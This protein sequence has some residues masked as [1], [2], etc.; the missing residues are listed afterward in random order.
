MG[1]GASL[2]PS[3]DPPL[4]EGRG[5]VAAVEL[6]SEDVTQPAPA[7][8]PAA[9]QRAPQSSVS[10]GMEKL[11]HARET[12]TKND[13]ALRA[14]LNSTQEEALEPELE[15]VDPHHHAWDMRELEGFN[16]FG[17]FKQQYYMSDQLLDDMVGG[18]H[19]VTHSVYAEAHSFVDADTQDAAMAPL[20]EVMAM[21]GLA[22][23]FASGK[24]GKLRAVAGIIGTA[25][26]AK[27]GA[28]V[29]PLLLACKAAAPNFRGIRVNGQHD[30]GIKFGVSAPGLYRETKFR[31]GFAL[32]G[33]HGLSFD[34]FLYSP[35][36]EDLYDLATTF[37]ETTIILNHN[38]CPAG[39]LDSTNDKAD[40]LV[41]AWKIQMEKIA[42]ECPN[43]YVKVG[44]GGMPQLGH[45]FDQ[46]DKPPTS[47]EVAQL[48]KPL[49]MWS[50]ETF[51]P[52]RCMV[53]TKDA[54]F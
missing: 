6:R 48:F 52:G 33:K 29:E 21:Q 11:L 13:A 10:P 28:E 34:A 7:P 2:G 53:R 36:L 50:V 16:L 27:F 44:G 22:A 35:Q 49:Y 43:V 39:A 40:A 47:D 12:W 32:L 54:L 30:P 46:R 19:N 37:P 4:S 38:G 18:G 23:Q 51:G 26:L 41:D 31:E 14:W 8:E 45:G 17:L 1:C 5:E 15:I 42:S 25:D 3:S 9:P 24:Y 20:G